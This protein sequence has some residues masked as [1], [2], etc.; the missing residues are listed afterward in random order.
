MTFTLWHN[1][2]LFFTYRFTFTFSFHSHY[3]SVHF[4]CI[5]MPQHL[6]FISSLYVFIPF[7]SHI[8]HL[9]M[10]NIFSCPMVPFMQSLFIQA[11]FC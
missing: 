5:S 3:A 11:R 6:A 10:Y 4:P 1:C 2:Y 7:D 8:K 9:F